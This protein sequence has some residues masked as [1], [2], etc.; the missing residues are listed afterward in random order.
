MSAQVWLWALVAVALIQRVFLL[1]SLEIRMT[2][3]LAG[4]TVPPNRL[5]HT[6]YIASEC[7]KVVLLPGLSWSLVRILYAPSAGSGHDPS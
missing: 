4:R 5:V 1:P 6:L 7:L 3:I 2:D